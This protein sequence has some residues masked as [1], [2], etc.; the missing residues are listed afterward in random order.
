[1]S[2]FK[3]PTLLSYTRSIEPSD[4]LLEAVNEG[5]SVPV[6]IKTKQLRAT[7]GDYTSVKK[8][9]AMQNANGNIHT[10]ESAY[11]PKGYDTLRMKFSIKVIS[12]SL[13]PSSCNDPEKRKIL[14]HFAILYK[15]KGGYD[16]LGKEYAKALIS[17]G[18]LWRN[19]RLMKDVTITVT[20]GD[21]SWVV[22][23]PQQGADAEHFKKYAS[24]IDEIGALY[25]KGLSDPHYLTFFKVVAEGFMGEGQEVF[26]SQP[27]LDDGNAAKT[28]PDGKDRLLSSIDTPE[29][30]QAVFH[31]EKVGNALRTIDRWYAEGDNVKPL[32]VEPLGIDQASF[33][34]QRQAANNH[35]YDMLEKK[36]LSYIETLDNDGDLTNDMHFVAA[37]FVRGGLFGGESD[38]KK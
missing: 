23:L 10:V 37:C 3:L 12:N 11:M 7:F 16:F 26:P 24:V 32:P 25:T 15:E 18:F 1:M 27:F 19:R 29:G 20:S 2:K 5:G 17:G 38:K 6:P 13:I 35:L 31:P 28:N 21:Q 30:R 9:D 4:G 34:A 14:E 22:E 8:R 33:L 36:M